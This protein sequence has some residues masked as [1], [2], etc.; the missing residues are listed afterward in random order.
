MKR[1]FVM[2]AILLAGISTSTSIFAQDAANVNAP[3]AE[4]GEEVVKTIN[5]QNNSVFVD[6]G[7]NGLLY[8]LNYDKVWYAA[9][10]FKLSTR[11]GVGVS[12]SIF[13][14]DMDPII[15]LGA[16]VLFGKNKH[17]FETGI[18]STIA[19]GFEETAAALQAEN[20]KGV[21]VWQVQAAREHTS[22]NVAANFGY[23]YQN[24]NGGL[25]FRAGVSPTVT[26]YSKTVSF[27]PGVEANISLGYTFKQKEAKVPVLQYD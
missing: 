2:L 13:E 5:F 7:G 24:P 16:S 23:R 6:V 1:L 8:S 4:V 10:K 17:Y 15:P 21:T 18:G 27:N 20:D 11:I 22:V 14:G 3:I 25:F 19:F 26:A 12:S 9:E